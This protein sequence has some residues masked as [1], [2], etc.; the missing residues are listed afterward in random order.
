MS[1]GSA[2][3]KNPSVSPSEASSLE[4]SA[5]GAQVPDLWNVTV[6]E[7]QPTLLRLDHGIAL[8]SIP[9]G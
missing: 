6:G 7:E 3:N 4:R 8:A 2:R 9:A 1:R 5:G